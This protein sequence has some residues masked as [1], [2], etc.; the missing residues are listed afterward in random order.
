MEEESERVDLD[1]LITGK[2]KG[3][4]GDN[5]SGD[6]ESNEEWPVTFPFSLEENW[7]WIELS[8]FSSSFSLC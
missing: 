2:A 8:H 5:S 1:G 4:F 7:P 6:C 3:E